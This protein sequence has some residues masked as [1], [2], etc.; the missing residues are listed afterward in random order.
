MGAPSRSLD[1]PVPRR[2]DQAEAAVTGGRID[3]PEARV[4]AEEE[5][6][7]FAD[8]VGAFG[9][10]RLGAARPT[11]P[12]GTSARWRCTSSAPPTRRR[13]CRSSLHQFVRGYPLNRQIDSHHWVDGINELQIR[14]RRH[15][16]ND[17]FVAQLTAVGPQAVA[18]RW[19]TPAPMRHLP[20]PF[21]PPIGWVGLWYLLDVG[22]TRDVWA[23]RIDLC[24]ATDRPME[25]HRRP[26]RPARRRP[27]GRVGGDPRRAVRAR[28]HRH[29]RRHVHAGLRR[30]ARRDRRRR[31]RPHPL[32]SPSRHRGPRQPATALK[33]AHHDRRDRDRRRH[34]P[35][36]HL[37]ARDRADRLHLQPVPGRRRRAAAVPHRTARDVPARRRGDRARSCR[38]NGCAGSCSATS[39]PTSAAR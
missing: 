11:A 33:G 3:R 16:T 30:R 12:G 7:R 34:L 27:R 5:F 6:R 29:R 28:A 26:R 25:P 36:L 32:R 19:G 1:R 22:F 38:S 21:G 9:P 8:L 4:I 35:H 24:A 20:I 2:R 13:R 39:R 23:H 10:E 37:R 15:L 14:E 31:V 18:G 17:E